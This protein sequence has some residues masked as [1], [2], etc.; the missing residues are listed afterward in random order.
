MT[1]YGNFQSIF[2]LAAG[3]TLGVS[4]LVTLFEDPVEKEKRRF[5]SLAKR[6]LALQRRHSNLSA[7]ISAEVN[8]LSDRIED[9]QERMVKFAD[10]GERFRF[11]KLFSFVAS[12]V[13]LILLIYSSESPGDPLPGLVR[14]LSYALLAY[15][16]LATLAIAREY[17]R[18]SRRYEADRKKMDTSYKDLVDKI[19]AERDRNDQKGVEQI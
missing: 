6:A 3:L 17:W 5:S 16:P 1:T 2:Q 8:S 7:A 18:V 12:V 13:G 10:A 14:Y 9:Y 15:A 11:V 19:W 4:G